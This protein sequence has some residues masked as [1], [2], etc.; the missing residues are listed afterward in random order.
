M[1]P[2]PFQKEFS[3]FSPFLRNLTRVGRTDRQTNASELKTKYR[4]CFVDTT[5][6][7]T[8][9]FPALIPL[10]SYQSLLDGSRSRHLLRCLEFGLVSRLAR[11]CVSALT[12]AA[13]EM[14][15]AS[16]RHLPSVLLKLSQI[17]VSTG[18]VIRCWDIRLLWPIVPCTV[19]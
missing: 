1:F 12:V 3:T 5:C 10:C 11:R 14:P 17:A 13:L 19:G 8:Q 7:L 18:K 16:L 9:V 15:D 6:L 2:M 4:H